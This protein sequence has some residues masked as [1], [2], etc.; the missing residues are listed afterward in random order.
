VF[1]LVIIGAPGAGKT[2]VQAALSDLLVA[3]D[4]R[5]V[6]FEVEAVTLAHPALPDDAWSEPVRAVSAIYR[7]LGYELLV[8]TATVES[9]RDLEEVIAAIAPDEHAVVRLEAEPETLRRRIVERE[10]DGWPGLDG[11]LAAAGRIAPVVAG[12]EGLALTVST[13]G[14]RAPAGAARIRAAFPGRL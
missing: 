3:D 14:A 7:R 10:P 11:L 9:R 5:H 6:T 12:L 4:V 2:G 13:E 8:V 1:A